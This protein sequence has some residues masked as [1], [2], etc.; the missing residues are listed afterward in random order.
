MLSMPSKR[1]S[2]IKLPTIGGCPID[3]T[4]KDCIFDLETV[5]LSRV[6]NQIPAD[7]YCLDKTVC[8]KKPFWNEKIKSNT[9]EVSFPM[10]P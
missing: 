6:N 7:S 9:T 8:Q 10:L 4:K 5:C 2:S 1:M 3:R